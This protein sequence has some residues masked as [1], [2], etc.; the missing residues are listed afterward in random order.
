[1]GHEDSMERTGFQRD[2]G[3]NPSIT[4]CPVTSTSYLT[5]QRLSFP[6]YKM[7]LT[8]KDYTVCFVGLQRESIHNGRHLAQGQR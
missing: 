7:G 6:I 1:M 3:S 4:T 5:F 8:H 2:S